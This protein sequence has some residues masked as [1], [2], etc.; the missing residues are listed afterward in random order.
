[1]AALN[2]RHLHYFWAVAKAGGIAR[3]GE[4]LHVTPQTISG[5]L[6]LFEEALGVKLFARQAAAVPR[7][8]A[9]VRDRRRFDLTE[10]GRAVL[11][12]AEEIFSLGQQ[13]TEA[14]RNPLETRLEPFRVGVSDAVAKSV[15]YRLLEPA[16]RLPE[17]M[18][19]ICREGKLADLLAE[20]AVHRLDI[21]VA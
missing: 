8:G 4:R 20:L 19:I 2:Y 21:V 13:L 15:A 9:R 18:R 7:K 11:T 1:M 6:S 5:Q 14:L 16:M 12:Y 17:P 10:A 3:A